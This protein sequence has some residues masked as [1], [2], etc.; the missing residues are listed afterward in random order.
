MRRSVA[1]PGGI[2]PEYYEITIV[3]TNGEEFKSGSTKNAGR[4]KATFDKYNHSAW[5]KG[6]IRHIKTGRVARFNAKYQQQDDTGLEAL[7]GMP[8]VASPA[9]ES[10]VVAPEPQV[11]LKVQPSAKPVTKPAAKKKK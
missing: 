11:G 6:A 9:A 5:N 8:S 7:L 1:H 4:M 10:D 2:H 3:A